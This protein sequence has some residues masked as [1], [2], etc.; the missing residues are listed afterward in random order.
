MPWGLTRFHHSGQSHFVT[1]CCYHRR[2]FLITDE[3]RKTFESALERVRRSF[4]LQV[5]AYVIMPEHVHLLLSEPEKDTLADALK[6]LKQGVSRRLLPKVSAP[7]GG[8]LKPAFGLSGER[9]KTGGPLKPAFGLSGEHHF[10][11]KR[12]YDF[13]IRDYPQFVE[14]LRYIHRNP[15]KAGLC[16]R[17][18]DWEWSSFRHYA[19][20]LEGPV[21]IESERTARKRERAAGRLCPAVELPHSSQKRA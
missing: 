10:W 11:Q 1:F 7:G 5:Y 6:S 8:P 15:V 14:K 12:Y 17:P 20:G 4:K 2:R 19:T 18:E 9:Q 16:E 13:N 3:S 21:E